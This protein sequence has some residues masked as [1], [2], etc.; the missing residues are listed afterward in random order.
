ML[1]AIQTDEVIK[2]TSVSAEEGI[3]SIM[4]T[5][6][7]SYL[8]IRASHFSIKLVIRGKILQTHF[9]GQKFGDIWFE[10]Y[11]KNIRA[12]YEKGRVF[13]IIDIIM[14]G[15]EEMDLFWLHPHKS[16]SVI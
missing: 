7:W 8:D 2:V 12:Y 6:C 11:C 9:L 14:A 15:N 4:S 5:V 1:E 13:T 3:G 10:I 16:F